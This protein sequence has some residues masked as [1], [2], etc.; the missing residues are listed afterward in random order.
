MNTLI[1]QQMHIQLVSLAR[2]CHAMHCCLNS[3]ACIT[4]TSVCLVQDL[5]KSKT[6]QPADT[7]RFQLPS[8]HDRKEL[9]RLLVTAEACLAAVV[10]ADAAVVPKKQKKAAAEVVTGDSMVYTLCSDAL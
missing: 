8:D 6:G 10:Q 5:A 1:V 7:S 2:A 9:D 3:S 4:T